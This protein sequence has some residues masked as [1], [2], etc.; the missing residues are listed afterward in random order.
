MPCQNPV[1]SSV[2][3]REDPA[4]EFAVDFRDSGALHEEAVLKGMKFAQVCQCLL[5]RCRAG[6][7]GKEQFKMQNAKC[8]SQNAAANLHFAL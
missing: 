7:G 8:K 6:R 3:G 1:R 4:R 5:D 2:S